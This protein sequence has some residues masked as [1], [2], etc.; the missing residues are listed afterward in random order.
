MTSPLTEPVETSSTADT[1]RALAGGAKPRRWGSWYVAEHRIRGM[2]AYYQTILATSI[3]NPLVYLFGLG[4]GLAALV[5]QGIQNGDA[6]ISYLAFVGP[7]LLATAAVTVAAEESTYPFMMGFKWNPIFYA[8]N[9]APLSG[10]QIANGMFIS[11]LARIVPTT[12]IYFVVM[13]FFGAV[14]SALG[15]IG[16]LT[17][18]FTGLAIATIVASYTATIE[19]DKGQMAMIMRFGITPM[20][21]FSGTFFPLA[22]LPWFL[23][24]IG[25]ISPLWHGTELGRVFA[26]GL[27]EPAWLTAVHIVVLAALVVVGWKRTQVVM[28]RRLNK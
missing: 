7:A 9:A 6:T 27:D 4:V 17:A 25:W 12:A 24:W 23:Q 16:I 11:I 8:M 13:I 2:R 15:F 28:T 19:E 20:F 10:S 21:L 22:T 14:P 5:P 3:G 1:A 18:S 26:Y